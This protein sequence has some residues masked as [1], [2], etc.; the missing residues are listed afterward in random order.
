[1]IIAAMTAIGFAAALL[2]LGILVPWL[3]YAAGHVYRETPTPALGQC[4]N[5]DF[6]QRA[7]GA[8]SRAARVMRMPDRCAKVAVA[9]IA[10]ATAAPLSDNAA[11]H[12]SVRPADQVFR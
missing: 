2:A 8:C 4:R 5:E 1:M 11:S 10:V 9:M 12:C 3:A 6:V 7:G